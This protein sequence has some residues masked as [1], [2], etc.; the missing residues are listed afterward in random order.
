MG[1][2]TIEV[3]AGDY[4]VISEINTVDGNY[5]Y[6]VGY[7]VELGR[8][9]LVLIHI[10]PPVGEKITFSDVADAWAVARRF[11][12][13]IGREDTTP[14]YEWE[15]IGNVSRRVWVESVYESK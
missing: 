13:E 10:M 4:G 6:I 7:W 2:R 9:E 1:M 15:Q 8:N 11:N 3:R 14:V 5:R 12:E